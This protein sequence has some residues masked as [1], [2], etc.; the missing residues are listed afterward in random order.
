M[1]CRN[2]R[3]LRLSLRVRCWEY[4][5]A[6]ICM[7]LNEA[8]GGNSRIVAVLV[9][10]VHVYRFHNPPHKLHTFETTDNDRGTPPRP[11]AERVI[12]LKVSRFMR[13][14]PVPQP[15]VV[16]L[17][18]EITRAYPTRRFNT[19]TIDLFGTITAPT[20]PESPHKYFSHHRARE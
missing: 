13:A 18:G 11:V 15:V 6:E 20:P 5:Y 16:G 8:C 10:R 7:S 4:G 3:H 1:I 2:S 14:F 17:S 9:G 12:P 19:A